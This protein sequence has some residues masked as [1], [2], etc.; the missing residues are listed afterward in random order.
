MCVVCRPGSTPACQRRRVAD[1]Q[2][3][4]GSAGIVPAQSRQR[5]ANES[6][7]SPTERSGR[8]AGL[9]RPGQSETD[10]LRSLA[11]KCRTNLVLPAGSANFASAACGAPRKLDRPRDYCGHCRAKPRGLLRCP[12]RQAEPRA[13]LRCLARA[14][15]RGLLLVLVGRSLATI[16]VLL[17]RGR[18]TFSD[19]LASLRPSERSESARGGADLFRRIAAAEWSGCEAGESVI[20]RG[21]NR[22]DTWRGEWAALASASVG[23][24]KPGC[25]LFLTR[26]EATRF[27]CLT[28]RLKSS[29]N[30]NGW[31]AGMT[32]KDLKPLYARAV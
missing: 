15:H 17:F 32:F 3:F 16:G 29:A 10:R 1:V 2:P 12:R 24:V 7:S 9:G 26:S 20:V 27:Q 28:P 6:E 31:N 23:S 5:E 30:L 21:R 18:T 11:A 19:C 14:K 8:M 4:A 25:C 13:V 22:A